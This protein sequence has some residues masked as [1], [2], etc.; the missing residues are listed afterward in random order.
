MVKAERVAFSVQRSVY[1]K[2]TWIDQD[3]HILSFIPLRYKHNLVR[4]LASMDSKPY[5][6]DTMQ[7]WLNFFENSAQEN[8]YPEKLF[9]QNMLLKIK[10]F[11]LQKRELFVR[12]RVQ[13]DA[14]SEWIIHTPH[15][16]LC[17]TFLAAEIWFVFTTDPISKL[18][19]RLPRATRL[20]RPNLCIKRFKRSVRSTGLTSNWRRL[21]M[22]CALIRNAG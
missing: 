18:G 7:N 3:T 17:S 15:A 2:R 5:S 4:T 16:A 20:T 6:E 10:L 13:I 8:W 9:R 19:D 12:L 21:F 1:Y 11:E 22:R 14:A